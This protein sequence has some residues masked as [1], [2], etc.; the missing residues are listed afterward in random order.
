MK[1]RITSGHEFLQGNHLELN[2]G[3][4]LSWRQAPSRACCEHPPLQGPW[5]QSTGINAASQPRLPQFHSW[6]CD[7]KQVVSLLWT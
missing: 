2:G 6:M 3:S 7:L 4:P 1:F 5:P